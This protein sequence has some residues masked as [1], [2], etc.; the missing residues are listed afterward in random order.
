MAATLPLWRNSNWIRSNFNILVESA[1]PISN[2]GHARIAAT[3]NLFFFSSNDKN[4][5]TS[6][7]HTM[8]EWIQWKKVNNLMRTMGCV[9]LLCKSWNVRTSFAAQWC[10]RSVFNSEYKCSPIQSQS[11]SSWLSCGS[12]HGQQSWLSRSLYCV[13]FVPIQHPQIY[14][15]HTFWSWSLKGLRIKEIGIF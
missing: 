6:T 7:V 4:P 11:I 13:R 10:S 8:N 9:W 1:T 12:R 2:P 5:T 14:S 3:V 15:L